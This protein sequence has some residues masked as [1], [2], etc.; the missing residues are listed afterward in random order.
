MAA[1]KGP[2]RRANKNKPA[3]FRRDRIQYALAQPL[4][5]L[6]AQGKRKEFEN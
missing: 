3:L 1:K 6:K 5:I 4:V 2:A